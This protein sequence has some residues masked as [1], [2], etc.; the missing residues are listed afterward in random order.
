MGAGFPE[1]VAKVKQALALGYNVLVMEPHD[2]KHLCWSSTN[3]NGYTNDQPEVS[4]E[5]WAGLGWARLAWPHMGVCQAQVASVVRSR[6][7]WQQLQRWWQQ[8]L[9]RR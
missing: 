4:M 1:D 6:W 7:W 8:Q 3:K 9:Q 2:A 5:G